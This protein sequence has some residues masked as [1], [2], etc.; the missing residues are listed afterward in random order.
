MDFGLGAVFGLSAAG[1]IEGMCTG[2][3]CSFRRQ[4][5]SFAQVR[6]LNDEATGHG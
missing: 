4:K 2:R 5:E 1:Q 6:V 3:R